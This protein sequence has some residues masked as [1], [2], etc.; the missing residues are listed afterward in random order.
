MS[1]CDDLAIRIATNSCL[2]S[3]FF[4]LNINELKFIAIFAVDHA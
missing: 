1:I 4:M 3:Y 2:L